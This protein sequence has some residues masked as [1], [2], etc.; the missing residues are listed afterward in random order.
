MI[1]N[2]KQKVVEWLRWSEQYTRTDM[3]YLFKSGGWVTTSK[4]CTSLGGL[5]LAT[6]FANLIPPDTYGTYKFLVSAA[7]IIGAFTL[8]GMGIAVAKAAAR[9]FNSALRHGSLA[10]LRWSIC[11]AAVGLGAAG[12]YYLQG[13]MTLSLGMMMIAVL[14]P[15]RSSSSVYESF[16]KGKKDFRRR[17]I[18]AIIL[19][20]VQVVSMVTALLL[21]NQVLWIF[22]VFLLANT[23]SSILFYLRT[24]AA[25][26]QSGES[27]S[28]MITYGKHL[29]FVTIFKRIAKYIDKILVWHYL[30][31][32]ELAVYAF[33][34]LPVSKMRSLAGSIWQTAFPKFSE[35]DL[36]TLQDTLDYKVLLMA[37]GFVGVAGVYILTAPF[38]FDLLFPEYMQSVPLTQ[39]YALG[40]VLF[41]GRCYEKVLEAHART[42]W[43]YIVQFT[44]NVVKIV[45]LLVLLPLYGVWGAILSLLSFETSRVML[46][47]IGFMVSDD[48]GQTK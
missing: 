27:R 14:Y 4:I 24:A 7:S 45:T 6:A 11:M 2:L 41:A 37:A 25:Y 5:V 16:L 28:D 36:S 3:V 32:V 31:G 19:E 22:L 18:Y 39:F 44:S 8:S 17:S 43:I 29:S 20:G 40:L 23:L 13:N 35:K 46:S 38:L 26:P 15:F 21:T 42:R 33:A 30:G 9:G 12:Y 10:K 1:Q 47:Y 34:E 48:Y